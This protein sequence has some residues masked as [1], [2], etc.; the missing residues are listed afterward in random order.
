MPNLIL[1]KHSLPEI[2]PSIPASKWNLSETGRLRCKDLAEKLMF[3]SPD[4]F[5]SSVEP[6][7][8][9]TAQIVARHFSK[10]FYSFVNLH[11]HDRTGVD[12]VSKKQFESSMNIFFKFPE[13]LVLGK[14]TAFQACER[15]SKTIASLEG[16]YQ[17]KSLAIVAHGTVITL[18]VAQTAGLEPFSF[19]KKMGLP[20][21]VVFSLPQLELLTIVE[22]AFV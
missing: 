18:F 2:I 5:I 9:E 8:I 4:I 13:R 16:R 6:K 15:F 3:Y 17:N 1:I 11:E 21:F 19:W 12:F 10:P 20:S 14:E 22:K 7:A